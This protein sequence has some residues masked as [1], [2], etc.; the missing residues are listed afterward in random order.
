M[1]AYASFRCR[2]CNA[3]HGSQ[4]IAEAWLPVHAASQAQPPRHTAPAA[5]S[6]AG[7][8]FASQAAQSMPAL[9]SCSSSHDQPP[10]LG[11]VPARPWCRNEATAA[12]KTGG[13]SPERKCG[14]SVGWPYRCALL[15]FSPPRSSLQGDQTPQGLENRVFRDRG[16]CL[17][18][19]HAAQHA[20]PPAGARLGGQ[21]SALGGAR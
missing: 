20:Q 6:A 14:R 13:A 3:P 17:S 12:S 16:A 19:Q 11:C 10:S 8:S 1:H 4:G 15:S 7:S 9:S 5:A 18:R 2:D 21:R